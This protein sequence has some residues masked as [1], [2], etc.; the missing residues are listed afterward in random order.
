MA[1]TKEQWEA[2]VRTWV[3]T[4]WFEQEG[5]NAAVF[6]AIARVFAEI[7]TN[8][9]AHALETYIMT[10]TA[11][12]LDAH[13]SERS[14][15]RK[16]G[17]SDASYRERIRNIVNSANPVAIRALVDALVLTG[18]CLLREHMTDRIFANRD[19]FFNRREVFTDAYYYNAFSIIV[20]NQGGG[21]AAATAFAT[22]V[23]AVNAA[24]AMGVLYRVIERRA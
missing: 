18:K 15:A 12:T 7:Q 21:P 2:K 22:I 3:P 20:E 24:K 10:S 9:E 23:S 19:S 13:G 4:W 11:P 1:L 17:E 5:N 14:I 16:A 6:A 8:A